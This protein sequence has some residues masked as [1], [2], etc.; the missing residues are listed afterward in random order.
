LG[1]GKWPVLFVAPFD[2]VAAADREP[3]GWDAV[4]RGLVAAEEALQAPQLEVLGPVRVVG[5]DVGA[6][7][8]YEPFVLGGGGEPPFDVAAQ[9]QVDRAPVPRRQHGY[10]D[11]GEVDGSLAVPVVE[12]LV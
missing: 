12:Q 11:L 6:D 3:D 7:V 9:V 2:V 4:H 10:P 1:A 5:V 8:D